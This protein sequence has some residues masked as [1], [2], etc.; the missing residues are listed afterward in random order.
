MR[1]CLRALALLLLA[2]AAA[3]SAPGQ[4]LYGSGPVQAPPP[5]CHYPSPKPAPEPSS[6]V[7]CQAG[8]NVAILQASLL[9]PPLFT[10]VS[11][12]LEFN[13]RP[14][15]HSVL[16]IS[17]NPLTLPGIPPVTIPLLI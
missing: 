10:P 2:S 12:V 8:H 11:N 15:A 6:H 3:A 9:T 17:G 7:C 14:V 13:E 16:L 1:H 5:G 4:R